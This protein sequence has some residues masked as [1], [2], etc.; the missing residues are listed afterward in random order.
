MVPAA[1]WEI[2]G[3][4]Q[5]VNKSYRLWKYHPRESV[6]TAFARTQIDMGI[7][8]YS[9]VLNW[10]IQFNFFIESLRI[11]KILDNCIYILLDL[12]LPVA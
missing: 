5:Y 8:F 12:I 10:L 2:H 3:Q 1:C 4:S 9:L 7:E 11:T 6:H